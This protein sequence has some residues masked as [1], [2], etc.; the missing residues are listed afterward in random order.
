M[1]FY[2]NNLHKNSANS[3]LSPNSNL[4]LINGDT[5]IEHMQRA[6]CECFAV[7]VHDLSLKAQSEEWRGGRTVTVLV[8]EN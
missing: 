4:T 1:T 5:L 7:C 2:T 8:F 6:A 3:L